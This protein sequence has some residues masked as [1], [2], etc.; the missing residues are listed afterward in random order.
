MSILNLVCA[1]GIKEQ[2]IEWPKGAAERETVLH[3]KLPIL[4]TRSFVVKITK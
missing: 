3:S 2:Q 1:S 4:K